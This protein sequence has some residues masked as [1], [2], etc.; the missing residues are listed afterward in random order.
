[1]TEEYDE[2]GVDPWVRLNKDLKEASRLLGA[3]EARWL[4]DTYY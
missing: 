4:V 2:V 3:Q 1:M